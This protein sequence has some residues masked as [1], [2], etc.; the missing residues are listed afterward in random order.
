[1]VK[2]YRVFKPS[3]SK[4]RVSTEGLADNAHVVEIRHKIKHKVADP[5]KMMRK[6]WGW[7]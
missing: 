5:F 3:K 1:M 4:K 2:S 6:M 7:W